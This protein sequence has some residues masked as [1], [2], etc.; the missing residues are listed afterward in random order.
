MSIE[1]DLDAAMAGEQSQAVRPKKTNIV[2]LPAAEPDND[3]HISTI[4]ALRF[5][6]ID[7]LS[8]AKQSND[9]LVY[10]FEQSA[11]RSNSK[12]SLALASYAKETDSHINL[13]LQ[14]L[15]LLNPSGNQK[16]RGKDR[17][18]L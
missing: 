13:V 18:G 11:I 2:L 15:S 6:M 12:N 9:C 5:Q 16:H 8:Y 10:A 3:L 4:E 7:L 17:E 1:T 14:I